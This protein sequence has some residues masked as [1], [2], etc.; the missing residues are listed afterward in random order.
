MSLP[1]HRS[2]SVHTLSAT[3]S[4][5]ARRCRQTL[6]LPLAVAVTL[7]SLTVTTGSMAQSDHDHDMPSSINGIGAQ[8]V[9]FLTSCQADVQDDFNRA[10][11]LMHLFWFAEAI[12][13][14]QD[15]LQRDADCAMAY[16]GIAMSH[17]G[18]PFAG[19]RN[20]QQL[21]RGH[22]AVE[23]ARDTGSATPREAAYITAVSELFSDNDGATQRAR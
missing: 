21:A 23:L 18:N 15:I 14:Y 1:D 5:A 9:D 11:A 13:T 10:V 6:A 7:A 16:W 22:A 12:N 2:S 8:H 20:Q 19:Q 3:V 17:W 4:L